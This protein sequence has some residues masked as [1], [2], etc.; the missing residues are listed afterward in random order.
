MTACCTATE[1]MLH[2]RRRGSLRR[3]SSYSIIYFIMLI[4]L[5]ARMSLFIQI[6]NMVCALF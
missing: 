4:S 1:S 6:R 3:L 5:L 2:H